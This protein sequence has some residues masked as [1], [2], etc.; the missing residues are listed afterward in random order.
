M[1]EHVINFLALWTSSI[2]GWI[3]AD[4]IHA[5][6]VEPWLKKKGFLP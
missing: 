5:K 6:W 1:A 2:G 4:I 3:V